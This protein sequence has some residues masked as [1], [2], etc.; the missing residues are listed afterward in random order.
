MERVLITLWVG[1][2]WTVGF[3]VAPVLFSELDRSTAGTL[4]GILFHYL[5]FAGLIIGSGLLLRN[6]LTTQATLPALLLVLMLLLIL[7]NEFGIAPEIAA[8]REAGF[9]AGSETAKRFGLLHG[10]AS[11]LYLINALFGLALAVV[12]ARGVTRQNHTSC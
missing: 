1:A 5:N 12:G 4:A 2:L 9:A 11:V 8:L 3:V 6:R 7:I 10:A